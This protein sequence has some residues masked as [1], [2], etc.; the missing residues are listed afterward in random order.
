MQNQANNT[1]LSTPEPPLQ[2][3]PQNHPSP[4][5]REGHGVGLEAPR[6]G[7]LCLILLYVVVVAVM[8]AATIVEKYQGTQYV[9]DHIYGAWW[10]SLLWALLTATAVCWFVKRRVRRFGV[11]VLH[12]SFVVILLG[13]LLTHLTARRGV[14]HLRE[15]ETTQMYVTPDMR[16]H[17]LPFALRLDSFEITYHPGTTAPA[18]YTSYL[19][20]IAQPSRPVGS[21]TA[22]TG[23]TTNSTT[24]ATPAVVSMNRI[25]A[26]SGYRLYQSS[27]D[28]D[29]HGTVL[30][31]NSDPWGIPVT[32]TGYALLFFALVWML[33]DPRGTFRQLLRSPL[34]KKAPAAKP[35]KGFLALFFLLTAGSLCSGV[36]AAPPAVSPAAPPA[37]PA[38]TAAAF[39]RLNMLYADRICPVQTYALDFTKKLHGRRSYKGFTPEQVLTGFLFW[40]DEWRREPLVKVKGGALKDRLQLPSY[41]SV[42]QFF[43]PAMGGYILGPYISDYYR[44]QRQDA[45]HKDVAKMDDRLM[46]VMELSQLSPLC[47]FPYTAADGTVSWNAPAGKLPPHIDNDT[48]Q[49]IHHFFSLMA[50]EARAGHYD[51]VDRLIAKL[52]TYQQK[53]SAN[54]IP[55]PIRLQAEYIYN[56]VPF[57][58][59]LFMVNLTMG[60]L[61]LALFIWQMRRK[62]GRQP[63]LPLAHVLLYATLAA[64]TFALGL[65]WTITGHVPMSNGYETMLTM[66]WLVMV[67]SLV[68]CRRFPI[69]LTF[70]FLLSGFFLLVSHIN[71]MDPQIGHLMPVLNS[72]LLSVHVSV[73]MMAFA[74]LSLTF[75]CGVTALLLPALREQLQLL[76]RLFLYPALTTLGLGI[77]IGAIWANI[78][79][80]TYWSWDPKE[81]WAL[82]TFM[83]YAVVVHTQPMPVFRRPVVYHVYMTL[84]FLTI[85]M[86]YFGVNYFLGGMHSYA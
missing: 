42:D 18:D 58:T 85:L 19:S 61:T 3:H 34:L 10:F 43:N 1:N 40:P 75:I 24:D 7:L 84:A 80:G 6:A 49:F 82:I 21:G 22:T 72:P 54:S 51:Q 44:G 73:I 23:S 71:Q 50:E 4:P 68:A 39:A 59:I 86:T 25:A 55:S 29:G 13:A 36:A 77:F 12:L 64:L 53:N 35:A 65:R 5:V 69:A 81:T 9:A 37:L 20:F 48:Q 8:A 32:Y 33:I 70:G 52:Q 46:L 47:L 76:S 66:A 79:W 15:G 83:V 57:A 16:T 63:A 62:S 45:F 67:L 26:R 78:S 31:M 17:P 27:Y 60:F 38:K 14:I 11:V 30:A 41:C 56:K 28:P 74:L 2:T